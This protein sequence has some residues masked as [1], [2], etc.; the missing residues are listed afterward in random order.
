MFRSSL[1]VLLLSVSLS[2]AN[3]YSMDDEID[4]VEIDTTEIDG[5]DLITT[6]R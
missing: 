2:W 3:I 1:I 4:I 6:S 5:T